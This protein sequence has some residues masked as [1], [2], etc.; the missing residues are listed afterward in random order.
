MNMLLKKVSCTA[1]KVGLFFLLP[2]LSLSCE[3]TDADGWEDMPSRTILVYIAGDNNLSSE[4]AIRCEAL[5]EGRTAWQGGELLVFTDTPSGASLTRVLQDGSPET[6]ADYGDLDSASPDTFGA[7]LDKAVSSYPSSGYGLIFFSHASGWL[8]AGALSVS[9]L[10]LGNDS[11][12]EME[13]SDFASAIPDG[14]LDFIVFETCLTSGAEVAYALRNKASYMMASAAEMLSPG[15]TPVYP[16]ALRFLMDASL[17]PQEGLEAVGERYMAYVETREGA[18][19]SA[20]LAIT[21]LGRMEALASCY[22]ATHPETL[23]DDEELES[24][25][26]FDRPGKYGELPAVARYFD[27]EQ[28]AE[29][30]AGGD[31]YAALQEELG[32]AV[33]WKASTERFM[34]DDGDDY[35]RYN[36]FDITRYCGLTVY[37]PRQELAQLNEAYRQTEWYRAVHA[38]DSNDYIE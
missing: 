32:R 28:S 13:L 22:A 9:T 34:V 23:Y 10:S 11:G 38:A 33:P 30:T 7:V 3:Q 2:V 35:A 4:V 18:Y 5:Y 19:K 1:A 21:D 25:Q 20:T 26:R 27:L 29:P 36:G 37:M 6:V 14:L 15:L 17:S 31:A 16:D 8:P 24:I 12:S